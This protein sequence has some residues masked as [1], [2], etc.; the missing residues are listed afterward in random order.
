MK[1][2]LKKK[3]LELL[4]T[5]LGCDQEML[6]LV[7]HLFERFKAEFGKD[8]LHNV[9]KDLKE[10]DGR[11]HFENLILGVLLEVLDEIN[12][13]YMLEFD[14]S[15][16]EQKRYYQKDYNGVTYPSRNIIMLLGG[17]TDINAKEWCSTITHEILHF[18]FYNFGIAYQWINE[19]MVKSL[20]KDT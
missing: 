9:V 15:C 1:T 3:S 4:L 11:C 5:I 10:T 7:L 14:C 19:R 12:R 13:K 20:M 17:S 18:I 2:K 8:I 16:L 6:E